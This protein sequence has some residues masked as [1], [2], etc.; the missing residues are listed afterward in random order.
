MKKIY[1]YIILAVLLSSCADILDVKYENN[2]SVKD[3]NG[4][5]GIKTLVPGFFHNWYSTQYSDFNDNAHY[6][7]R[8]PAATMLYMADQIT[9]SWTANA[10]NDLSSTPRVELNNSV[11]YGH[12]GIISYY[13]SRMNARIFEVNDVLRSLN[14]GTKVGGI[15]GNGD[16]TEMVKAFCYF[17]QGISFG[18]LGLVFDKTIIITDNTDLDNPPQ[19]WSDYNA[20]TDTAIVSLEKCISIAE[21]HDFSIPSTWI[22]GSEYSNIEL[23]QLAH[24]YIARYLVYRARNVDENNQ[25]DWV[26]VLQHSKQ[27]I[28][29]DL[30]PYIDNIT[31]FNEH[32]DYTISRP[33]WCR[34]DTRIINMMDPTYPKTYPDLPAEGFPRRAVSEDRRIMSTHPDTMTFKYKNYC[35]FKPDRGYYHFSNYE[36]KRA[37]CNYVLNVTPAEVIEFRVTENDL[38]KAEA[39][40]YTGDKSGAISIINSGTRIHRGGLTPLQSNV[41]DEDLLSAIFYER[42][43]E[44]M[45]TGFGIGFFDMR[46]RDMLEV[47]TMLHFP[48]PA[49]E[50]DV[51]EKPIYTFGGVANADGINTSN[52]G[53]K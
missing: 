8:S 35:I 47:G 21:T 38:L 29:R 45:F 53:W 16:D 48:I 43:I 6:Y 49:K 51:M 11:E 1:I 37:D 27:G 18:N 10:A 41:S 26:K 13:Y 4:S 31:W 12:I 25:I 2:P 46:R 23:A 3:V 7:D 42:D 32:Y 19:E 20:I 5:I 33:D 14:N 9:G 30:A 17:I 15:S 39:M 40:F 44:L 28:Q 24:S 22:N 52:G 50:L 36:F 34:I